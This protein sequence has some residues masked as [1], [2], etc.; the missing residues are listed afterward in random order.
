MHVRVIAV[1]GRQPEWVTEGFDEYARRLPA[2]WRFRLK[3]IPSV[4]RG[5]STV[6]AAREREGEKILAAL[7]RQ[8]RLIALDERGRQV[9]SPELARWIADWQA[10]GRD[11]GI[12]IGGPDGLS[13]N[14]I[15]RAETVW[16][17]SRLTLPH[18]L[19]RVLLAEQL[20]R[21]WTLS[22]GHP[23]HRS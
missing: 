1:G 18:G 12:V 14:C 4:R 6:D 20:Y 22:T 2:N 17:L 11:L 7:Q 19:V 5:R 10:D 15:D 21:A 13:Q 8:E 16:S 3:Q 23:Y 9:S